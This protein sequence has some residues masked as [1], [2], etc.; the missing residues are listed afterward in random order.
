[1]L[2]SRDPPLLLLSAA[3]VAIATS[4]WLY[5]PR[6]M[7]GSPIAVAVIAFAAI[8]LGSVWIWGDR[9][10]P[11]A[12]YH[13]GLLT[14]AYVFG[15]G[16]AQRGRSGGAVAGLVAVALAVAAYG[17]WQHVWLDATRA[18]AWFETPNLMAA[19]VNLALAPLLVLALL[20]GPRFLLL[21]A[22]A[23]L[24]AALVATQSRGGALGLGAAAAMAALLLTGSGWKPSARTV[25][26]LGAS[27]ALGYGLAALAPQALAWRGTGTLEAAP[28]PRREASSPLARLDSAA[29]R[30]ELYALAADATRARPLAG[31]GYLEFGRLFDR[32]QTRVP[33]YE[34]GSATT[35]VHDDY[36]QVLLELG[37]IGVLPFLAFAALP[38]LLGYRRK[39]LLKPGSSIQDA[40]AIAALAGLA[41]MATHA[42][43]DFPFY[44]PGTL[45]GYGLLLGIADE[46]LHPAAP[47]GHEPRRASRR[48]ARMVLAALV[49]YALALP[50][51]AAGC[52]LLARD[53]AQHGDIAAAVYWLQVAR[54]F[55]PRDWR[56]HW[57]LAAL[58]AQQASLLRD[59]QLAQL[60][61]Q[62]YEAGMRADP[63]DIHNLLGWL[64][65]QR[66]FGPRLA[67]PAP[68]AQLL[69]RMD[70]AVALAPLDTSVRVERVLMLRYLGEP[71]RA[72]ETAQALLKDLPGDAEVRRLV[73]VGG[74]S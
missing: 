27:L 46:R 56:R 35:F 12:V 59:P 52:A 72:A 34:P 31:N 60:A 50:A 41:S 11:V 1:M 64:T 51:A 38:P 42:L 36:L 18:D 74:Q 4:A 3:A 7:L 39:A 28:A 37:L 21:G 19:F 26:A 53:R 25:A 16:C 68:R 57:Q 62:E 73:A 15:R 43:V 47:D 6:G 13:M 32:E 40:C 8:V 30:L 48:V 49:A 33:S 20:R 14:G 58:L 44:V 22:L 23:A 24:F 9:Y 55:D 69:E 63:G 61:A 2:A 17:L 54:N 71:Q 65:L 70:E 67:H 5:A 66:S 10:T 45:A 29:S